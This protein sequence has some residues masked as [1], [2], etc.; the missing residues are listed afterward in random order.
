MRKISRARRNFYVLISCEAS[1]PLSREVSNLTS[2]HFS[3]PPA[4]ILRKIFSITSLNFYHFQNPVNKLYTVQVKR[5]RTATEG[6]IK[7]VQ[8]DKEIFILNN[9]P[10]KIHTKTRNSSRRFSKKKISSAV[11]SRSVSK[12]IYSSRKTHGEVSEKI[13]FS[14]NLTKNVSKKIY[15]TPIHTRNDSRKIYTTSRLLPR[16][17]TRSLPQ[18]RKTESNT[19]F[20]Y[21]STMAVRRESCG[22][23]KIQNEAQSATD[24]RTND[25][26]YFNK[27]CLDEG[28]WAQN[29]TVVRALKCEDKCISEQ[30]F[31]RYVCKSI[32]S[33][34]NFEKQN[35]GESADETCVQCYE[36]QNKRSVSVVDF[37]NPKLFIGNMTYIVNNAK[38]CT[39]LGFPRNNVMDEPVIGEC[40]DGILKDFSTV[41][42]SKST[43]MDH[44]EHNI[45]AN[46]ETKNSNHQKLSEIN[47][48]D[49]ND[50]TK[51]SLLKEDKDDTKFDRLGQKIKKKQK[52]LDTLR[53][54]IEHEGKALIKVDFLSLLISL[55]Q[56]S[57]SSIFVQKGSIGVWYG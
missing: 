8:G 42:L 33:V 29:K 34:Q 14:Q 13:Y 22:I 35:S 19:K 24:T 41:Q 50:R 39:T 26:S 2:P 52:E 57:K 46:I 49:V 32:I 9:N 25:K 18:S 27:K 55:K 40:G 6:N 43:K 15:S 47:L 28:K 10:K 54:R 37:Q 1:L 36:Y 3:Q 23:M 45:E 30:Y 31:E 21:M 56:D 4:C 38:M 17:T 48:D 5:Y 51:I 11:P 16:Y 20:N 44:S 12:G 7:S 53:K